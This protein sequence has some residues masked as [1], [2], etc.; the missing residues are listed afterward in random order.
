VSLQ[1]SR[2]GALKAR[3]SSFLFFSS[4]QWEGIIS[5]PL[6]MMGTLK[7]NLSFVNLL[8]LLQNFLNFVNAKTLDFTKNNGS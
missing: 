7:K 6:A 4:G 3:F 1:T 5:S 8:T 2:V